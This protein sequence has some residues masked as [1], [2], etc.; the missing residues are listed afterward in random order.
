[1]PGGESK[2]VTNGWRMGRW[3]HPPRQRQE[4]QQRTSETKSSVLNMLSLEPWEQSRKS[5]LQRKKVEACPLH[6]SHHRG[7]AGE[8]GRGGVLLPTPHPPHREQ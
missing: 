8:I 6:Q 7:G 5:F 1:M 3:L 2:G 4:E